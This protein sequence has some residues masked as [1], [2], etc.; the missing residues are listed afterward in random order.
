MNSVTLLLNVVIIGL[1]SDRR[2]IVDRVISC[3]PRFKPKITEE[4]A[5]ISG[6]AMYVETFQSFGRTFDI[7]VHEPSYEGRVSLRISARPNSHVLGILGS[8]LLLLMIKVIS[9][10]PPH[11]PLF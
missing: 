6:S 11:G 8:Y 10:Q 5:P 1:L 4:A 2:Y 7:I 9:F 3:L